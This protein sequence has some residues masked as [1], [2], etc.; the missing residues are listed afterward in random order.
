MRHFTQNI[1][2]ASLL[3]GATIIPVAAQEPA[4]KPPSFKES[5]LFLLKDT[6]SKFVRLAEAMPAEK[7]S[8]RP[9]EGVRSIS[10]VFMHVAGAN[11][12][13]MSLA[14]VKIPAGI[15]RDAEKTVTE[16]DKVV[17]AIKASFEHVS[18]AVSAMSDADM[19][20]DTKLFG[21]PATYQNVLFFM[22]SHMHE[23]LGQSIAYARTNGVVPPW[24]QKEN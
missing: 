9:G 12:Y 19:A 22:T 3:L 2:T 16:K 23:H 18:S 4:A 8:W 14:G 15:S 21:K 7:Y 10:E 5:Y 1:V 11:Y 17:A 24:S 13:F 6:E 20:K